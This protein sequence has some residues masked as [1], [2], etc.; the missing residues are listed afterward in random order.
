V[1]RKCRSGLLLSTYERQRGAYGPRATGFSRAVPGTPV[2]VGPRLLTRSSRLAARCTGCARLI[3]VNDA[4]ELPPFPMVTATDDRADWFPPGVHP[5]ARK[6]ATNQL[7]RT[8]LLARLTESTRPPAQ[9]RRRTVLVV[10]TADHP[11]AVKAVAGIRPMLREPDPAAS[12]LPRGHRHCRPRR[13]RSSRLGR[14]ALRPLPRRLTSRRHG[15]SDHDQLWGVFGARSRSWSPRQRSV[16]V[17]RS[18]QARSSQVTAMGDIQVTGSDHAA[19][20]GF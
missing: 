15:P 19:P 7:W 9:V 2:R 6:S 12:R 16:V 3:D 20:L 18:T 8:L 14:T 4:R 1:H 5:T 17:T 11:G 10:T 13:D